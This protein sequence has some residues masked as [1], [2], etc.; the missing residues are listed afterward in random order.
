MI[1]DVV[2]DKSFDCGAQ[3]H[4]TKIGSKLR[5]WTKVVVTLAS[6]FHYCR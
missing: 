4:G 3:G 1:E 2:V 6:R 5:G